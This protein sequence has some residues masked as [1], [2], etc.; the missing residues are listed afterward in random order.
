M[1]PKTLARHLVGYAVGLSVFAGAIPYGLFRLSAVHPIHLPIGN[2]ARLA[3]A[4]LLAGTGLFFALWSNAALLI[5]GKGGPTAAFNV[6]ISPR[7]KHLVV[8][9]PYR[10]TRNPMVFGA[11]SFY[12]ALVVYWNSLQAFGALVLFSAAAGFYLKAT[13]EQRLVR[14]F[15]R[16]YEEYRRN[17][18][19]IM[20]W[21]ARKRR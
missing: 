15:G 17:T 4:L 2:S 10:H 1:E 8:R 11:L 16:E 7:T 12:F 9:G 18:P 14:D 5:Q 6:A 13:E 21:P 19:M 3:I 20:P